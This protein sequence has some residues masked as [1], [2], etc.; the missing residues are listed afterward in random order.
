MEDDGQLLEAWRGGDKKAGR[1]LVEGH[2]PTVERFFFNKVGDRAADLI[3]LS[4]L[5]IVE[6]RSRVRPGSDFRAYLLGIARNVLYE[7]YRQVRKDLGRLDFESESVM[8]ISPTPSSWMAGEQEARLLLEALKR[9]PI[10]YQIVLELYYWENMRSREVAEIL[11]MPEGTARSRIRRAKQLLEQQLTVL[12][13]SP[14]ELHS[15]TTNL[16]Q[17]AAQLKEQ[18]GAGS[19]TAGG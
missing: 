6:A 14:A 5:R 4:F 17:W 8:D 12:A 18:I 13:S 19:G 9:I 7:H 3:Q 15:T 11:E 2:Y 10:D 16:E 1:R